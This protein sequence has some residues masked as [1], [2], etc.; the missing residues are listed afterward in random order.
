[1]IVEGFFDPIIQ[2][3]PFDGVRNRFL[4]AIQKKMDA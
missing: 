2:R 3:I 1:M 4:K